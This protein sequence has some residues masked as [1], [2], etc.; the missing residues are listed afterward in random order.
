MIDVTT[1]L[2][3]HSISW[4]ANEECNLNSWYAECCQQKKNLIQIVRF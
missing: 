1:H 2:Y 4:Q 3:K